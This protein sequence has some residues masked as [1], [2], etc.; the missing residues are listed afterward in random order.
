MQ[1]IVLVDYDNVKPVRRDRTPADADYNVGMIVEAI[2]RIRAYSFPQFKDVRIR[3]YGGWTDING[4]VLEMATWIERAAN[5]VRGRRLGGRLT[6]EL[7][8]GL[9]D[10]DYGRLKGLYRDGGQKMVDTLIVSDAV[11]ITLS[12]EAKVLFVSD[13]EDMLPG[14]LACHLHM[15]QAVIRRSGEDDHWHNRSL[16]R[17]CG[18]IIEWG[19]YDP[20]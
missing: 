5:Q 8:L 19:S 10:S 15:P 6:A 4:V 12:Y 9:F 17:T 18:V 11:R 20:G 3:L 7:A 14:L 1:L 16:V 13:D 2:A